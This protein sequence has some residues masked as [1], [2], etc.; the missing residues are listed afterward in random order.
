MTSHCPRHAVE[1]VE[2]PL[3]FFLKKNGLQLRIVNM[4]KFS[5]KFVDR[6]GIFNFLRANKIYLSCTFLRELPKDVF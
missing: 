3:Q 6:V 2:Q 1:R 5:N 4:L